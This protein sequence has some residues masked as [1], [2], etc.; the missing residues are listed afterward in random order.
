MTAMIRRMAILEQMALAIL[1]R[2][3]KQVVTTIAEQKVLDETW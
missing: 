3:R 2:I 1:L